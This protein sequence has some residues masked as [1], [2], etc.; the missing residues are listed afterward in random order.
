MTSGRVGE[1]FELDVVRV[2][3]YQ[4]VGIRDGV[5]RSD[6]RVNDTSGGQ[7]RRP[8][9][10][11]DPIRHDPSEMIEADPALVERVRSETAMLC[12]ADSHGQA[13]VSDEDFASRPVRASYRPSMRKSSTSTYH[14]ALASA[15]RTVSPRW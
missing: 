11:L 5:R 7:P 2:A 3:A 6:R 9:I 13:G 15:S 1:Q 10:Q 8:F 4:N 12:E 14:A